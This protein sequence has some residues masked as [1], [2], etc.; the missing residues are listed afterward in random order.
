M[1]EST[2]SKFFRGLFTFIGISSFL[3]VLGDIYCDGELFKTLKRLWSNEDISRKKSLE[4][5][6]RRVEEY[7]QEEVNKRKMELE[8]KEENYENNTSYNFS[9]NSEEEVSDTEKYV[10][11]EEKVKEE[12]LNYADS[13]EKSNTETEIYKK[14]EEALLYGKSYEKTEK[15]TS[16]KVKKESNNNESYYTPP[17]FVREMEQGNYGGAVKEILNMTGFSVSDKTAKKIED[18]AQ[19]DDPVE[20]TKK[21]LE[22]SIDILK[23]TAKSFFRPSR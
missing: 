6:L 15:E 23:D 18:A 21:Y 11:L 10:N 17:A 2:K 5:L 7:A 22:I 3:Y 12:T 8:K 1:Y 20:S 14:L 16:L 13:K 4:E 9:Q 19:T